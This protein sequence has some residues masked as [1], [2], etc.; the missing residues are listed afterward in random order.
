MREVAVVAGLCVLSAYLLGSIPTTF[1]SDR[2]SLRRGLRRI[3]GTD[4]PLDEQLRTVLA[5]PGSSAFVAVIDT[6]KVL[7]AATLTWHAVLGVSPGGTASRPNQSA[8]AFLANQVLVSWQSAALWAG[9]AA[10]VGHL[11]PVWLGFRGSRGQAPGLALAVVYAPVGFVIGVV[12]F[13]TCRLVVG[14]SRLRVAVLASLAAF[15]A[16]A[17]MAWIGDIQ[18]AWGVPAGPEVTL[19]AAVLAGALAV[20]APE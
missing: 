14:S 9:L 1:L 6:C 3:E 11:A 18:I 10:V 4:R 19:W 7:L 12:A 15:V 5:G 16:W 20:R 8:V 13:F 2:R 17:W